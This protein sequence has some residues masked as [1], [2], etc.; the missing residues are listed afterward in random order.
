MRLADVLVSP[1][2]P[3]RVCVP[4]LPIPYGTAVRNPYTAYAIRHSATCVGGAAH[5]A[6]RNKIRDFQRAVRTAL[7]IPY[8]LD[9]PA[10][11]LSCTSLAFDKL[12]APAPS[13]VETID[14]HAS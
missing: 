5:L 7:E 11:G 6:E 10:L 4:S 8:T 2:A 13:V 14:H 9:M 12:V 3:A 1:A